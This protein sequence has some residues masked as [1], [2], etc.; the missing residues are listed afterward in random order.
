ME[1]VLGWG[2]KRLPCLVIGLHGLR[3]G[4]L[5]RQQVMHLP[6]QSPCLLSQPSYLPCAAHTQGLG[7]KAGRS[8]ATPISADLAPICP[9]LPN[10]HHRSR[11][12]GSHSLTHMLC[13]PTKR[14]AGNMTMNRAS[15]M[16]SEVRDACLLHTNMF[17]WVEEGGP[18][19]GRRA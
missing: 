10:S 19:C 3:Q 14:A 16:D 5:R 8:Q 11:G 12:T 17:C 4:H 9:L 13:H 1:P 6:L 18:G 2:C 7:F 15:H